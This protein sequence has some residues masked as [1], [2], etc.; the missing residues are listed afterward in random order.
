MKK[1]P[2]ITNCPPDT[3]PGMACIKEI[4]PSDIERLIEQKATFVLNI[5]TSWCPDCTVRQIK[6]IPSFAAWLN[7]YDIRFYQC[8]VQYERD[9]FVSPEHESLVKSCGGHGYPRTVLFKN[10][11]LVDNDNV[12]I[13]TREDLDLLGDKF[14]S[15]L[16]HFG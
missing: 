13:M 2:V 5:V 10:G 14:I 16:D 15:Q 7:S 3:S 8:T 9:T 6:H 1:I 4:S 12:E 11:I